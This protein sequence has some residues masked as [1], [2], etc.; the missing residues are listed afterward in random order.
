M[1]V[2]QIPPRLFVATLSG[3]LFLFSALGLM[4]EVLIEAHSEFSFDLWAGFL[5]YFTHFL[6][7]GLSGAVLW[8][9]W[10]SPGHGSHMPG[11]HTPVPLETGGR[12][13]SAVTRVA[14]AGASALPI[15]V[16]HYLSPSMVALLPPGGGSVDI[17]P[18]ALLL[19]AAHP[20]WID[21]PDFMDEARESDR[22]CRDVV[23]RYASV[24]TKLNDGDWWRTTAVAAGQ[25]RTDT[26]SG[27]Q[28]SAAVMTPDILGVR[29]SEGGLRIRVDGDPSGAAASWRSALPSLRKAFSDTGI[30]TRL[31]EVVEDGEGNVVLVFND[32]SASAQAGTAGGP[33]GAF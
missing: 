18:A 10:R 9:V 24:L 19:M 25:A 27:P 14:P 28:G 8:S 4:R 15:P 30:D 16:Y 1:P 17:L 11:L 20:D 33:S 21:N 6:G 31:L 7:L 5:A 13:V 23:A 22:H 3:L 26:T 12:A 32:V 2:T 29:M